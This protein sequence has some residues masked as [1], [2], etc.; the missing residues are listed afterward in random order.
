MN[1]GVAVVSLV[2]HKKREKFHVPVISL[3]SLSCKPVQID[4]VFPGRMHSQI[5][6]FHSMF[7]EGT[8][9]VTRT[10]QY[11]TP[12][13]DIRRAYTT[14]LRSLAAMGTLQIPA[15]LPAAHTDPVVRAPLWIAKQ[16]YLHPTGYG[17]G[18]ALNRREGKIIINFSLFNQVTGRV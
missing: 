2:T 9:I 13:K 5:A 6:L 11:G 4:K 1:R 7:T 3:T 10:L 14:V 18:A 15:N 16:D 12:T 17:V 8:T